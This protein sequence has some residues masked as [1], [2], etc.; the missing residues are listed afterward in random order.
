MFALGKR[1]LCSITS[2]KFKGNLSFVY[3]R[4]IVATPLSNLQDRFLTRYM[5]ALLYKNHSCFRYGFQGL[6][7]I[8]GNQTLHSDL[9][10]PMYE[11]WIIFQTSYVDAYTKKNIL[12]NFDLGQRSSRVKHC[13]TCS[14]I[15]Q[16]L[17][18][19]QI[20]QVTFQLGL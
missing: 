11:T 3:W 20:N 8:T 9:D 12:Y 16:F 5:S 18:L 17:T 10:I 6:S 4:A 1:K 13:K 14:N 19:G 7:G 2:D 15:S